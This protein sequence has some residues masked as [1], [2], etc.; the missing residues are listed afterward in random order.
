MGVSDRDYMR[1]QKGAGSLFGLTPSQFIWWLIGLNVAIYLLPAL[2]GHWGYVGTPEDG[3]RLGGYSSEA[4]L[5]GEVWNLIT[6]QFVHQ[7]ILHLLLNMAGLYLLGRQVIR[8]IGILS[9]LLLYLGG[10]VAGALLET[11]LRSAFGQTHIV[12]ASAAVLAVMAMFVA[13]M[14]KA[15]MQIFPLPF[16]VQARTLLWAFVI[17][18]ALFGLLTVRAEASSTAYFAHC[19]GAL[20]GLAHGRFI[21]RWLSGFRWPEPKPKAPAVRYTTRPDD[22]KIIDA[23]FTEVADGDY[24]AVL[25]KINRTGIGSLT[26]RERHILEQASE[27]LSRNKH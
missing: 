25:D 9:F 5:R 14:P 8:S 12:G 17:F 22:T 23:E 18:N 24:N 1:G 20:F 6:Y 16:L 7:S 21:H 10:G 2:P 19:G 15:Q 13:L 26:P 11:A 4:F 3:Y 27:R